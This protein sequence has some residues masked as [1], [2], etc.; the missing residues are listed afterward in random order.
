M[1]KEQPK[2][3]KSVKAQY[4]NMAS[5]RAEALRRAHECAALTIPSLIPTETDQV[6]KNQNVQLQQPWQS[7]GSIGVNTLT[8]K[9]VMTL[10]PANNPF[11]QLNLSNKQRDQLLDMEPQEADELAAALEAG[12]MK[13]EQDVVRDME[14][15]KLRSSLFTAVKHMLVAGNYL[16]YVGDTIKGYTLYQ[17]VVQRDRAGNVCKIIV[18][19]VIAKTT[20]DPKFLASVEA[21]DKT[22]TDPSKSSKEELELY[23]IVERVSAKKWITHQEV[24]GHMVPGTEGSYTDENNPWIAL[25]MIAVDGED[26][27]RSYVEEVFGDL[28][29]A[30]SL[31]KALVEGAMLSAKLLWLANPHG[32]TDIEDIEDSAN[33][34]VV[35]GDIRDI[36][37][38]RVDKMAD[39]SVAERTLV[40]ILQ[41]LERSF[42]MTS[43]VQ[44]SG[45]R[46]TAFEISKL[47]Q[48]IEDVLGGQYSLLGQELQLPIV[49]RWIYAMRKRGDLPQLPKGSVVPRIVTGI[50][51]LGRGQDLSNLQGFANDVLAF[52]Q[53]NPRVARKLNWDNLI[54]RMANGRNV[55]IVGLIR[56]DAELDAEDAQAQQQ[57]QANAMIDKAAGP[58][59]KAIADQVSAAGEQA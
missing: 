45:E 32:V 22:I 14:T 13:V 12:L 58:A 40:S 15:T 41:R 35:P 37:A 11:F 52:A 53:V 57:Q 54:Q 18:R 31:S 5:E 43:S 48:E 27:G 50:D 3:P 51:A 47:S 16:L 8:A 29:S 38:L 56:P 1:A 55:N 30:N 17:Y 25:R 42:L 44:R 33:G 2:A 39:F 21:H 20:L 59:A 46:V 9:L 36:Q 49:S 7:V 28:N 19:E 10:L 26:Y 4:S 24:K 6:Q 34:D 23:T